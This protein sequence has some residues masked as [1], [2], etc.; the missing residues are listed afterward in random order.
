MSKG[1]KFFVAPLPYG[2]RDIF[3]RKGDEVVTGFTLATRAPGADYPA[4]FH[5]TIEDIEDN[6]PDSGLQFLR[7]ALNCAWEMGLRPDGYLDTRE[8][9]RGMKAHLEDMRALTFKL[10]GTSKP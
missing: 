9:M 10:S 7:A 3:L 8:S 4:L 5:D 2:G 1:W 6:I